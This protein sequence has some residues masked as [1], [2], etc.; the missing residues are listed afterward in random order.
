VG[1]ERAHNFARR[2]LTYRRPESG[3]DVWNADDPGSTSA[4]FLCGAA[5]VGHFFLRLT[6]PD[7]FQMPLL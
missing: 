1:L 2:T 5:G 7:R 4:D 3:G 6:A